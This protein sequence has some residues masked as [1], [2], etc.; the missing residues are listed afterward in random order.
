[1]NSAYKPIILTGFMP[2]NQAREQ[3]LYHWCGAV[4]PQTS[5]QDYEHRS[6]GHSAVP[7][8][9]QPKQHTQLAQPFQERQVA[10]VTQARRAA[11]AS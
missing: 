4:E 11:E 5:L 2:Y 9:S 8:S 3:F 1:M 10:K 6:S 7:S